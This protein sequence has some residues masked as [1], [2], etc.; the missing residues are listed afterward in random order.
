MRHRQVLERRVIVVAV[1]LAACGGEPAEVLVFG[2]PGAPLSDLTEL[3]RAEFQ[4]GSALFNKV[5]TQEEGLGPL[6]NEN[7]CSA[8]HTSPAP[9]GTTGFERVTRATRFANGVCDPLTAEGGEN[10]RRKA[11]PL[12]RAHG[13]EREVVPASATGVGHLTTPFL[14]GLGLVE[15][16]PEATILQRADA[17]DQNGDGI[18][19]RPG[20]TPDGRYARFGRKAD[21]ATIPEFVDTAIRLEMGLTTP[22][23]PEEETMNGVPLPPDT[24]PVEEPE[25]GQRTM[26]L[27]TSFVRFLTPPAPIPPRSSAHADTLDAGRRLFEQIGCTAC[28]TPTMQ[29]GTSTVAA[30]S[31]KTVGLYSDLLLHDMGPSLADVCSHSASPSEVRTEML[32]GVRYRPFLMHDGRANTIEEAILAHGGEGEGSR[33]A[34]TQLTWL[35]Q[36]YL[37]Q[38][39]RS[40]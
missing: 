32:M 33:N 36:Y 12:L 30:L 38:F 18:S 19:G 14:F 10:I 28:H 2:E 9:G 25:V 1:L 8:C 15:A 3:Q 16:I 29:T 17:D 7:Q 23:H 13:I 24:D 27:L 6:F 35:R 11:T 39:L 4:A 34:F 20:R 5:Y 21:V 22:S 37:I 31:N 40:L 26:D